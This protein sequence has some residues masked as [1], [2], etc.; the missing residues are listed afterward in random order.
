[1][2]Q[3]QPTGPVTR[4][5]FDALRDRLDA[6]L[7]RFDEMPTAVERPRARAVN[8][9][10][11]AASGS[12]AAGRA[13]AED[14]AVD[15]RQL[16]AHLRRRLQQEADAR[17]YWE[18]RA[19]ALLTS[20]S[21]RVTAPLRRAL[22]L[23]RGQRRDPSADAAMRLQASAASLAP[24]PFSLERPSV[25]DVIVCV[26]DGIEVVRPCLES[27]VRW[28]TLP[29]RLIV[30][31]D[32]SRHETSDYLQSLALPH[33]TV[34]RNPQTLGY[35]RSANLGLALGSSPYRLLL[36][37]DTV[38][39]RGWLERLVR[40][41]ETSPDTAVVGPVSNNATYQSVP[42]V[43][44]KGNW[45]ANPLPVPL[46]AWSE[47]VAAAAADPSYPTTP[48][49][50]GMCW[51][52]RA[53]ALERLG[54]FDET[55]SP[56][57]Y[58]EE[59]EM[60]RRL[61][62]AGLCCRIAED[63][64]VYHHGG[65]TFGGRRVALETLAHQRYVE[66]FGAQ[67]VA[68]LEQRLQAIPALDRL[69]QR[70]LAL[71]EAADRPAVLYLLPSLQRCGGV[72]VVLELVRILRRLGVEAVAAVPREHRTRAPQRDLDGLRFYRD[73]DELA[74]IAAA[75]DAVVATHHVTVDVQERLLGRRPQ[76]VPF[77]FLQDYEPSFYPAGTESQTHALRSY[78]RRNNFLAISDWVVGR[79]AQEHGITVEKVT[80]GIDLEVFDPSSSSTLEEPKLKVAAMIR[81]Q[82][83][84]RAP[85][86]TLE[87]FARLQENH[88]N[89]LR[90]VTFGCGREELAALAPEVPLEHHGVA[91]PEWVFGL[92][93]NV[94]VFLDLSDHQAF[95]RTALEAMAGGGV[96][97]VPEEGGCH[98]FARHDVNAIVCDSADVEAVVAAVGR[99]I[100]DPARRHRLRR[101]AVATA[102]GRGAT[103]CAVEQLEL[104]Q[105]RIEAGRLWRAGRETRPPIA[106]PA[107]HESAA[108]QAL[109]ALLRRKGEP[110]PAAHAA[111]LLATEPSFG[112]LLYLSAHAPADALREGS[113]ILISG[114]AA[115]SEM[116]AARRMGFG[117]VHG[118]EVDGELVDICRDRLRSFADMHPRHYDGATLPFADE[119]FGVVA[120]GHVIEHTADPQG[121]LGECLRV[122]EPGGLLLL[123]FP[124][125]YHHTE[126]HTG[127]PSLEWLPRAVRSRAL[128]AL[129]RPGSPLPGEVKRRCRTI[130]E[131]G[132]QQISLGGVRA[133]L[134]RTGHAWR[135]LH[136]ARVAPGI[137]RCVVER[138]L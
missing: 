19:D 97:V 99:V 74:G 41:M 102:L 116:I 133:A 107:R 113:A 111:E 51:M 3:E 18:A 94:D 22:D 44:D 88:P 52:V 35:T 69:R 10:A 103:R 32:G 87:V 59:N 78:R 1:V 91:D 83:P 70:L 55:F 16:I 105:R 12:P 125:R 11:K 123:E 60:A 36:N 28:S 37:S 112:R 56:E 134:R 122:L 72:V 5:E 110:A 54:L 128:L 89:R 127:L 25:V 81:P 42:R 27:V 33:L 75:F 64:M 21:W 101:A 14:S 100:D 15:Q 84:W 68:M 92:L 136:H 124:T 7:D 66:R 45:A 24:H 126:L 48:N 104:V 58:G 73:E 90:F 138:C 8:G 118:V 30:V 57:G 85:H 80:G 77:Y 23:L 17:R 93:R 137:V 108:R 50:S 121:Y 61:E 95:G 29:M 115:G 62:A 6:F 65:R 106:V 46:E 119:S 114:F 98:E 130:V 34:H 86:R 20:T 109:E 2:T 82:T 4:Q 49:V 132:L 79:M 26:K 53:S 63:C 131:S 96:V 31:D 129:G 76:L 9:H 71:T 39:T 117:A 38:V 43:L 67:A 120:S 13:P 135:M 40:C 47:V